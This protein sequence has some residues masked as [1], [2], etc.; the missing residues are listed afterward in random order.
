MNTRLLLH[1]RTFLPS[2][3]DGSD[4]RCQP[5]GRGTGKEGVVSNH[6]I[7]SQPHVGCNC[8]ANIV[9]YT[10]SYL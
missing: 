8:A 6:I 1:A 5:V 9:V 10:T 3:R 4:P 2:P 7:N